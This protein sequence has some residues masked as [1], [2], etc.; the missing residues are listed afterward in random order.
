MCKVRPSVE[1]I[2]G[3]LRELREG[4]AAQGGS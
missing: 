3:K 1:G 2:P 4:G